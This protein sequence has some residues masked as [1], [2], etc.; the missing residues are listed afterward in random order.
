MM[1]EKPQKAV[2]DNTRRIAVG[3]A[4]LFVAEMIVFAVM[5]RMSLGALLGG[6]LGSA[7][8]VLNFYM[9]GMAVQKAA[10][11]GSED[12]A[13]MTLRISY[14]MRMIGMVVVCVVAF[15]VPFADGVACLVP[16]VFPRLTILALQLTG[17]VKD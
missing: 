15:A 4:C 16:M 8:A 13:R 11:S 2:V 12:T 17:N 9:L 14:Q 5:G 10:A 1:H 6:L 7:Y 3:T